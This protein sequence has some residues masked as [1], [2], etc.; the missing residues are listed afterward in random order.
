[1][2]TKEI[3]DLLVEASAKTTSDQRINEI[4]C[5]L[6]RAVC[7][8][9]GDGRGEGIEV[10]LDSLYVDTFNN[11][12]KLLPTLL[13][14]FAIMCGDRDGHSIIGEPDWKLINALF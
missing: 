12:P 3:Y 10:I 1:M 14:V 8:N 9:T 4:Q 13:P 6:G 5:E 11:N 2:T 7:K